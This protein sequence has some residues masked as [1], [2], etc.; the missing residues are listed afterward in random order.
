MGLYVPVVL[1]L[2]SA[3]FFASLSHLIVAVAVALQLPVQGKD[4]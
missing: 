3:V 1:S 2:L 4:I